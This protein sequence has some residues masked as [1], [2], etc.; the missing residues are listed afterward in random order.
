MA[1]TTTVEITV[2]DDHEELSLPAGALETFGAADQSPADVVGDLLVV[3][4]TQRLH[5]IVAHGREDPGEE[6]RELEADMRD[7]FEERFGAT[8]AEVTGHSH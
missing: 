3:S 1:E 6:L 5:G 2:G 8:F 7:H 4:C